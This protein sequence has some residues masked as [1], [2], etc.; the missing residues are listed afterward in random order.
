MQG[1]DA[2]DQIINHFAIMLI[3]MRLLAQLLLCIA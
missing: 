2:E 1:V 3:T